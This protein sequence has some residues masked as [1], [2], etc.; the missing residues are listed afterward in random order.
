MSRR[1]RAAVVQI[2]A[3]ADK[4]AN[5]E[6]AER[7]VAAAAAAG[8]KLIALPEMFNLYGPFE[9]IVAAAET[10]PGLT[11]E[12]LAEWA[13][14]YEVYLVGGSF[15][16]RD[17]TSGKARNT[18]LLLAPEGRI[19][20]RYCKVHLFDIDSGD[21]LRSPL[22]RTFSQALR[23]ERGSDCHSLCF[24]SHNRPRPLG[25]T[26]SRTR[27]REPML[28][29]C[30]ESMRR[31]STGHAHVR[32]FVDRRSLGPRARGARRRGRLR[33]CRG[34]SRRTGRSAHAVARH[35]ASSLLT[36]G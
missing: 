2:R 26:R 12:R 3:N 8:A 19:V 17:E 18:S 10:I 31:T 21:L 27:D 34:R 11:S 35:F 28:H 32:T 15:A 5:L 30:A 36:C 16:E 23:R 24:Y 7:L 29:T 14:R 25:G 1:Y 22:S 13:V 33:P 9:P 4:L 20:A 6:K